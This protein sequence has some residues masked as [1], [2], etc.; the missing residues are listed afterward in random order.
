MLEG[1]ICRG[2]HGGGTDEKRGCRRF[3]C[4]GEYGIGCIER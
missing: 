2:E 1:G 4:V 3:V